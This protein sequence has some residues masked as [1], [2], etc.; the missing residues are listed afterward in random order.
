MR[1]DLMTEKVEI[2]P[3]VGRSALGATKQLT[4]ERARLRK[5]AN[6]KCKVKSGMVHRLVPPE[7]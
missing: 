6:G 4:V 5:I 7:A 3:F 1:D 2:D